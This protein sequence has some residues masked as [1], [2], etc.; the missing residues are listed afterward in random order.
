LVGEAIKDLFQS[1]CPVSS[2]G[3]EI[4]FRK[5]ERGRRFFFSSKKV[6][7]NV[8]LL[9]KSDIIDFQSISEDLK[10]AAENPNETRGGKVRCNWLVCSERGGIYL[11]EAIATKENKSRGNMRNRFVV[12]NTGDGTVSFGPGH[13][14]NMQYTRKM[15]DL[16][17]L[18]RSIQP[19]AWN[20]AL[21]KLVNE[22]FD[23][24]DF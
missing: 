14:K 15:R 12:L 6:S 4:A 17:S 18:Y 21:A 22:L 10:R 3:Y 5:I 13:E 20:A 24:L 7:L 9:L 2:R 19:A 1:V 11:F 8:L 16:I 23:V